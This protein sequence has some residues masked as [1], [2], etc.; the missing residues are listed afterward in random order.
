[1]VEGPENAAEVTGRFIE[2][3]LNHS[4][5]ALQHPVSEQEKSA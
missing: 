1:M 5:R 2:E 3:W 4:R